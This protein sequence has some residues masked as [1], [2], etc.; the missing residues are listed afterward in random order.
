M[1]KKELFNEWSS[2]Y[3]DSVKKSDKENTYPFAGYSLIKAKIF[4]M[5]MNKDKPKILEMGIGTGEIT[6][7][8]YDEGL[9]I[10]G[11][12]LSEKMIAESRISMPNVRYINKDFTKSLKVLKDTKFDVIIFSYSIHHVTIKNQLSLLNSLMIN[13]NIGGIIIISDVMTNTIKELDNISLKYHKIWDD[14]E[15]YPTLERYEESLLKTNYNITFEQV[16][17]CSGILTLTKKF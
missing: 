14:D 7:K 6:R 2:T 5:V 1:D 12:D 9:N 8:L 10:T 13:I 16:S 3:N 4:A 11:V 15:Y 17:F